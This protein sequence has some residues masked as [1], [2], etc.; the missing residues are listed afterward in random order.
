MSLADSIP[1]LFKS[2]FYPNNGRALNSP[3]N[4]II[5]NT[6]TYVNSDWAKALENIG[7]DTYSKLASFTEFSTCNRYGAAYIKPVAALTNANCYSSCDLLSAN[8]QDSQTGMIYGTDGKTGAGGGILFLTSANVVKFVDFFLISAPNEFKPLP[9]GQD[10]RM[11]WRQSVRNG[12]NKGK[13]I[14]DDGVQSDKIFRPSILDITRTDKRSSIFDRIADELKIVSINTERYNTS[15]WIDP[16]LERDSLSGTH[17][18][19]EVLSS[20]ITRIDLIQDKFLVDS[21]IIPKSINISRSELQS[22]V[23]KASKFLK[24]TINSFVDSN[25]IFS[26]YRYLRTVPKTSDFLLLESGKTIVAD[27]HANYSVIY[28]KQSKFE[29]WNPYKNGMAIQNGLGYSNNVNSKISFFIRIPQ[30]LDFVPVFGCVSSTFDWFDLRDTDQW[31]SIVG[32]SIFRSAYISSFLNKSYFGD[33]SREMLTAK[34]NVANGSFISTVASEALKAAEVELIKF[35][36]DV[37]EFN[38]RN[39]SREDFDYEKTSKVL[40]DFNSGSYLYLYPGILNLTRR[41]CS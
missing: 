14:E 21:I 25:L 22:E 2:P 32:S 31:K 7:N 17:I 11:G 37:A 5:F 23:I 19:F 15:I 24:F 41:K 36:N 30:P 38:K 40:S 12:V 20:W 8:I 18:S 33:L 4:K 16:R 10:M 39:G 29:G 13:L 3:L 27:Y 34:L 1:Q 6:E 35:I 9:K 28:N 26:T